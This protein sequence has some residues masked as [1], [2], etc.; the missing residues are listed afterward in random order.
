MSKLAST[1]RPI[2]GR[3]R[4]FDMEAVLSRAVPVFREHGY[5]GA[6]IDHLKEA[7]GLTAGSIYK[8]FKDKKGFFAAAFAHYV[9]NRQQQLL[10]RRQGLLT[11]RERIAETLRFYLESASGPEGRRGCLVLAGLIEATT[12]ESSL[13]DAL[14]EA[15]AGNR[16][17]LV[18]M[19]REGQEDG[20][21][22]SD[23]AVEPCA[24]VLLGLLQGLRAV[25]KLHDLADHDALIAIA[26]K[27]LD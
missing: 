22:R 10:E 25:G 16:V 26:L 24:D 3:P 5:E 4:A 14:T 1:R 9:E 23:L 12:L 11:G 21:I 6:S 18:A 20:S 15:V 7:T 17:A 19:L 27:T 13:H 8:A 2:M